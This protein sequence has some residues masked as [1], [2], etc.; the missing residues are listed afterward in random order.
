[1][2]HMVAADL[3]DP[4]DVIVRFV[5]A[6]FHDVDAVSGVKSNRRENAVLKVREDCLLW[7]DLADRRCRGSLAHRGVPSHAARHHR[8][9]RQPW[10]CLR[11]STKC[12]D[13]SLAP[14][15]S[16]T[17]EQIDRYAP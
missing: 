6:M 7:V 16:I 5:A 2:I 13:P 4:P 15:C 10:R 14:P 8:L 3:Q 11:A 12:A 1:M 17:R 9:D